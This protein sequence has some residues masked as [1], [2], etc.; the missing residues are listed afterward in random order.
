VPWR[1][2]APAQVHEAEFGGPDRRRAAARACPS[3]SAVPR[4]FPLEAPVPVHGTVSVD[5]HGVSAR[6]LGGVAGRSSG[7]QAFAA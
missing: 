5:P 7:D 2:G 4:P 3:M 1:S 6:E